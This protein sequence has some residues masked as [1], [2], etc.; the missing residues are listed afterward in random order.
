MWFSAEILR[1]D[2]ANVVPKC[3]GF[4]LLHEIS[5]ESW[6]CWLD[7]VVFWLTRYSLFNAFH[8]PSSECDYII[9]SRDHCYETLRCVAKCTIRWGYILTRTLPQEYIAVILKPFWCIFTVE[10][11]FLG[12]CF[13]LCKRSG[14][15]HNTF[16]VLHLKNK[17]PYYLRNLNSRSGTKTGLKWFDKDSKKITLL[18]LLLIF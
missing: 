15:Q 2:V 6:H 13:R 5:L 8:P 4:F 18:W 3:D 10:I 16:V 11:F 9:Q 1:N 14:C 7:G 12:M 17:I